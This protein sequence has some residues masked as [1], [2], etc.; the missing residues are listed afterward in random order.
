MDWYRAKTIMIIFLIVVN[1]GLGVYIAIDNINDKKVKNSVADEVVELLEKNN[2]EIDKKLL[3]SNANPQNIKKVNAQNII[4]DY[5]YF[6]KNILGE[7]VKSF[8][9]NV[10]EN[11]IGKVTF[12]GDNFRGES[13][14]GYFLS[15]ISTSKKN[16]KENAKKY[17]KSI[18][19]DVKDTTLNLEEKDGRFYV[20][21]Q[22]EIDNKKT[23]KMDITVE[24]TNKG[25]VSVFGNWYNL[26]VE[27]ETKELKNITGVMVEYMNSQGK[28]DNKIKV[29]KIDLGY[30][31]ISNKSFNENIY[32][33]PV[34]EITDNAGNIKYIN[35]LM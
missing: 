1:L 15:E 19:A 33:T 9:D 5:F 3:L 2:I 7:N 29:K 31:I 28:K 34:W 8:A 25:V 24:M 11:N 17:L 16:A 6:S 13:F 32:L 23:F 35:A 18:G 12:N 22:R 4:S 30:G 21:F 14:D 20:S 10:Y 27:N 26:K